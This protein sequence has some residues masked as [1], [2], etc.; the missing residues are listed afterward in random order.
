MEGDLPLEESAEPT[1]EY[2]WKKLIA[3]LYPF[4]APVAAGLTLAGCGERRKEVPEGPLSIQERDAYRSIAI[5]AFKNNPQFEAYVAA[6]GVGIHF[7]HHL[8]TDETLPSLEALYLNFLGYT[9]LISKDKL[10]Q[11]VTDPEH[12]RLVRKLLSPEDCVD[13]GKEGKPVHGQLLFRRRGGVTHLKTDPARERE[14]SKRT[15]SNENFA[16]YPWRFIGDHR[17]VQH[18]LHQEGYAVPK[19]PFVTRRLIPV[20]P[21]RS[22]LK[23]GDT[24]TK[25]EV[26]SVVEIEQQKAS[27]H[28]AHDSSELD[29]AYVEDLQHLDALIEEYLLKRRASSRVL[30][31]HLSGYASKVGTPEYNKKLSDQRIRTIQRYIQSKG[32]NLGDIEFS[33]KAHG[34]SK[35][36]QEDNPADRRVDVEIV[37][38]TER[39][40]EIVR[41]IQDRK[42]DIILADNSGSML[43]AMEACREAVETSGKH[44]TSVMTFNPNRMAGLVG[45][46]PE[47]METFRSQNEAIWKGSRFNTPLLKSLLE[48]IDFAEFAAREDLYQKKRKAPIRITLVTDVID[49]TQYTKEECDKVIEIFRK[50]IN[51]LYLVDEGEGWE[52]GI[53]V[54]LIALPVTQVFNNVTTEDAERL[55]TNYIIDHL[56]EITHGT[57]FSV[58]T[59][60]EEPVPKPDD[61]Y[62]FKD[63]I[64]PAEGGAGSH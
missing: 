19:V 24:E 23:N 57:R 12:C 15:L 22:D 54:S 34:E 1:S 8:I 64:P 16:L 17:V 31:L 6:Q 7:H 30:K 42:P 36:T 26:E 38:R 33:T 49:S 61:H 52:P 18:R 43:E 27:V 50:Q 41:Q 20:L 13:D 29:P 35:A 39:R 48:L 51:M 44:D 10:G 2:R 59:E 5:D 40:Q 45:K 53:E 3:G 46:F 25:R 60:K 9:P 47:D 55:S 62:M 28:F 56:I 63:Q 32:V 58:R 11:G 14:R 37:D 4:W 21:M